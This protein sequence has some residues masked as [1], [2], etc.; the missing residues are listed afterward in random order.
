MTTRAN[1]NLAVTPKLDV[2]INAGY[3]AQDVR[4]PMSDDS[5]TNGVAGN[6]YGGPG[7]QVQPLR[8][9]RH[10]LRLAAVHA[11]R[12]L[13]D[14]HEPGHPA[15]HHV[16]E[17]Q[18]ASGRVAVGARKRRS[19][20][21]EPPRHAALPLRCLPGP[22][23]RQPP[24]LQD[25][26]PLELLHVHRR[27][28]RHARPSSSRPRFNRRR[29]AGVQFNRSEFDR[30]GATRQTRF[31]PAQRRS[32]RAR[33]RPPTNRRATRARSAASSRRTSP[34][35]IASSSP[36]RFAP[37]AT[38]RSA[39]T[40]RRC[41]IPKLVSVVGRVGRELLPALQLAE[42]AS[43]A[44]R[45]RRIGRAARHH[46]R[47]AVLLRVHHAPRERRCA[48]RR[49]QHARQPQPQARALHGARAWR[50]RN[51]LEQPHHDRGHVLQQVVEGR[52][53]QPSASAVARHGR[54]VALRE[55]RQGDA[56]RAAKR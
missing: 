22:R 24:R 40:S 15:S 45:V 54:D 2:A 26:Q 9:R 19:R 29:S 52:A 14:V 41:S 28:E 56:T 51:V 32:P 27:R 18:L 4:L 5:G 38:A 17:R 20:L 23:R 6:T 21:R 48:G 46:R 11:A 53:H 10:A 25:R 49:L 8:H 39:R 3:T 43:S 50:G 55:P 34:S 37:I 7:I 1:F 13:S 47:R 16:A 36:A 44:H 31:R 33:C 30:N 42:S 12:R 35:A